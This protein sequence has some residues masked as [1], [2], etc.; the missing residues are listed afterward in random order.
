MRPSEAT[1]GP[2]SQFEEYA[3]SDEMDE[4]LLEGFGMYDTRTLGEEQESEDDLD[5]DV[6]GYYRLVND[7]RQELFLGCKRR[8]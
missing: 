1:T 3:D 7:G 5:D 2:S 8:S 4:M 6:E